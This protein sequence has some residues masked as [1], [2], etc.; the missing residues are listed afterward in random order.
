MAA[1]VLHTPASDLTC[2]GWPPCSQGISTSSVT[3]KNKP[4]RSLELSQMPIFTDCKLQRQD[5][6]LYWALHC[7]LQLAISAASTW[8]AG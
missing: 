1:R 8:L 5:D 3:Q 6:Q 2:A 4:Q 7:W